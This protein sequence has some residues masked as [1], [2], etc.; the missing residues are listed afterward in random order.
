MDMT[1]QPDA[2]MLGAMDDGG[3][4]AEIVMMPQE[5]TDV[6]PSSVASWQLIDIRYNG[7]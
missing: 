3:I 1:P 7:D 6:Y 2:L 4:I 5:G